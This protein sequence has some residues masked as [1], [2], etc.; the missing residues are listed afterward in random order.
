LAARTRARSLL[1]G[2]VQC[3]RPPTPYMLAGA[4]PIL[5]EPECPAGHADADVGIKARRRDTDTR[6][7]VALASSRSAT[8][9][10]GRRAISAAP[11][12]IG[13]GRS[14]QGSHGSVLA[15]RG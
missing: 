1:V 8:R 2:I 5:D 6:G 4:V 14:I 3:S 11:S 9:T 10:S 7:A 15:S 13:S 12:P